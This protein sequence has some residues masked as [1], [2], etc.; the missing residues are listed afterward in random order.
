MDSGLVS[1]LSTMEDG[2]SVE[3]GMSGKEGC[4]ALPIA[5]GLKT[6]AA[7]IIVQIPGTAFRITSQG[8]VNILRQLPVLEKRMQQYGHI[9]AMQ[10]AQVAGCNRLH[11]VEERLARWLLMSQDRIEADVVPLTHESVATLLGTRRASVS[12]AAGLLQKSGLITYDRSGVKIKRRQRLE[13]AACE[14]YKLI[15]RHTETWKNESI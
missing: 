6:S 5:V 7:R 13:E 3:V 4:T 8:L 9:M 14:C 1:V 2:K 12:V 11:K 10:S 15:R